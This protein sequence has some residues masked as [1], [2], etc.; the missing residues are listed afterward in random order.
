VRHRFSGRLAP[1]LAGQRFPF[2]PG[3]DTFDDHF[4][5]RAEMAILQLFPQ[6]LSNTGTDGKANS[7]T[8]KF[9]VSSFVSNSSRLMRC[10]PWQ[11]VFNR[12]ASH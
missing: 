2:T 11:A 9:F 4:V 6:E 10:Q 5:N 7:L 1:Q 8:G 12:S 3:L